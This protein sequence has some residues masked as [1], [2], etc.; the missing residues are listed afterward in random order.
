MYQTKIN[1]LVE[2]KQ[3][4]QTAVATIDVTMLKHSWIEVEYY[5]NTVHTMKGY[6]VEIY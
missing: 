5:F 3:K 6:H 4:I 2:F 1:N